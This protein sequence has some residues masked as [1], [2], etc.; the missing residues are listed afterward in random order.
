MTYT[1]SASGWS[2]TGAS[3]TGDGG[4]DGPCQCTGN[5]V[6]N[7]PITVECGLSACGADYMTYSCSASGWS[8]TGLACGG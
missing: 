1:C 4:S 8:W 6:G 2:G 5:G 7:V 3:C